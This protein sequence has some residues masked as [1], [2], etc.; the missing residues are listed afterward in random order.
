MVTPRE[1]FWEAYLYITSCRAH[2]NECIFFLH[3]FRPN[4]RLMKNLWR[5]MRPEL[6]RTVGK[7]LKVQQ[8]VSILCM[9]RGS[10]NKAAVGM[11]RRGFCRNG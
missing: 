1:I 5:A 6:S 8:I 9:A 7:L 4:A 11:K 3:I 2:R 10:G